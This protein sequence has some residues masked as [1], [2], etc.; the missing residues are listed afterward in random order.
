MTSVLQSDPNLTFK[1]KMAAVGQIQNNFC[2]SLAHIAD[3]Y[4]EFGV[5]WAE[6]FIYDICFAI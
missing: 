5:F 6:E 2:N 1:S 4:S 3:L